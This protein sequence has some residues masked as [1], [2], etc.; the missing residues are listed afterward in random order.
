MGREPETCQ[1]TGARYRL[2]ANDGRAYASEAPGSL[3]GHRGLRIYGRLDCW[4]A[5][6]HLRAGAYSSHRVFFLDEAAAIAAGF[7][8]CG[9]CM[10]ERY[11][12]WKAG[13]AP[14]TSEYPWLLLP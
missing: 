4:S 6:K 13:G 9:H 11:R 10:K 1:P 3:G 5:L 7:R 14:G 8:P 12:V 2:L